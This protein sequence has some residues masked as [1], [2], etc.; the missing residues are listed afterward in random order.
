MSPSTATTAWQRDPFFQYPLHPATTS[1]GEVALPILYYDCASMVAMFWVD[2][3]QAQALAA[4]DGL[5]AVRFGRG[6]ALLAMA[7]YQYRHTA[8]ADYN[9]VGTAIAVVPQG[10]VPP[11]Q[12]LLQLY[13]PLDRRQIGFQVLDLPVTTEAACAAGREIWGY[14]KFVTGIAFALD[15]R[16][17]AGTVADPGA[18][19]QDLLAL[20][21]RPGPAL[22][23]PW[24][25]LVTYSRLQ[26]RMLR[27][28]VV[29]RGG[30]RTGMAGSVRLRVSPDST[31]RMAAR[32]R[33]LGLQGAKPFALMHTQRLQLRLNEG[34]PLD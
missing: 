32:L 18:A 8:I 6:K 22:A 19:G 3:A 25:D 28:L 20:A 2:H 15:A 14:P 9:E 5:Q 17:F 4:P 7:F 23:S 16:G 11:P 31:H 24:L 10:V 30:G 33:D 12:P 27:T 21:G 34:A 1:A 26:G 29:T 13:A